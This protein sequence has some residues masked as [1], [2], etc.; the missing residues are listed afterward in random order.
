MSLVSRAAANR[1]ASTLEEVGLEAALREALDPS[2]TPRTTLR[3]SQWL[4]DW[5]QTLTRAN[6]GTRA[7]YL[8]I[9]QIAW[10]EP[11][12]DPLIAAITHKSVAVA[13]TRYA[14][15]HSPKTVRNALS[16]LSSALERAVKDG[17]IPTNPARD[18]QPPRAVPPTVRA[19]T[20]AEVKRLL[21]QLP[22]HYRPLVMVMAATGLRWGEATALQVRDVDVEHG[23]LVISRAWKQ[24]VGSRRVAGAPKSNAAHR[25]VTLL[26]DTLAV[27][28]P[29]IDGKAADDL[30]FTTTRGTTITH[31]HFHARIWKPA[32]ERAG[33]EPMPGPHSLRHGHAT[34][35]VARGM[36]L[37]LLQVRLGHEDIRTTIRTYTHVTPE[38]QRAALE[39]AM[40]PAHLTSG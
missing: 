33:I 25:V 22:E 10:V 26:G 20:G 8:R 15:K 3:L 5:V 4:S 31:A 2:A 34:E 14:E 35:M 40:A 30:V 12:G 17:L 38:M 6:A 32:G 23:H 27:I 9:T 1:F 18:V 37:P 19:L 11:M 21:E 13:T 16:V 29:L 28:R 39:A 24:G 36:P 7:K